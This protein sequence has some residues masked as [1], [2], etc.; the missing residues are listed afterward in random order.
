MNKTRKTY[1]ALAVGLGLGPVAGRAADANLILNSGFEQPF[2]TGRWESL[3]K[4]EP[5]RWMGRIETDEIT[6]SD[7]GSC[8]PMLGH[9]LSE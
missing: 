7:N 2:E 1:L 5:H 9:H 8:H 4:S 3:E 6:R